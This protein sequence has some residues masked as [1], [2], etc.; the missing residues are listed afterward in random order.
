MPATIQVER[1]SDGRYH[2]TVAEGGSQSE[3]TVSLK[4]GYY[5][6]LTAKQVPEEELIERSFQFLLERE[7]RQSILREFD[8][9]VIGRYFPEYES[10]IRKRL[11]R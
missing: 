10:E 9:T 7:S 4:P 8:L 5:E 1:S 6:K 3:Y 2:V 11:A